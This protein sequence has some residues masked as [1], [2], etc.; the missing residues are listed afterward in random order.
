MAAAVSRLKARSASVCSLSK[1]GMMVC[2]RPSSRSEMM[3]PNSSNI[4]WLYV[5]GVPDCNNSLAVCG[6]RRR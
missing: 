1:M 3:P 5:Q 2:H 4:S 6:V